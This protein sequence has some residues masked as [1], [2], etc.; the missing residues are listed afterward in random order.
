MLIEPM[1]K[2][3]LGVRK[4]AERVGDERQEPASTDS[5]QAAWQMDVVEFNCNGCLTNF[6]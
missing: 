4:G 5:D 3:A 1:E 2:V 6:N